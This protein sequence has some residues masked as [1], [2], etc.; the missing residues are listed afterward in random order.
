MEG[1]CGLPLRI[2]IQSQGPERNLRSIIVVMGAVHVAAMKRLRACEGATKTWDPTSG[3]KRPFVCWDDDFT[4]EL[5][6]DPDGSIFTSLSERALSGNY[7]PQKVIQF[8]GEWIAEDRLL[9]P[10]DRVL[11]RIP[12]LPFAPWP[13]LWSLAEIYIAEATETECTV[14]YVTTTRHFGR[15]IWRAKFANVG[16]TVTLNVK[17]TAGPGSFWFWLGL[18]VARYLMVRARLKAVESFREMFT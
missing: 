12:L 11:Q 14:G 13:V 10:G 5:G 2:K 17:A 6:L 3:G 4:Y 16:D 15:G 9:R 1:D 7:Y 8:Y 18:P